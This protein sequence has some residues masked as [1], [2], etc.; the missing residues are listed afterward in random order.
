MTIDVQDIFIEVFEEP[1]DSFDDK[2]HDSEIL[3]FWSTM[4]KIS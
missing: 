1:A 4:N 3:A 2:I